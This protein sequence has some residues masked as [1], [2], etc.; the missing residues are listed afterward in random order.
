MTL[1]QMAQ[2]VSP[3]TYSAAVL[4]SPTTYLWLHQPAADS[5]MSEPKQEAELNQFPRI[6]IF[7]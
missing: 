2:P 5:C 4:V 7:R 3:V 1:Q 6:V